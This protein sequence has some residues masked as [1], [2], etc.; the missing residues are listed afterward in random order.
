MLA[1][2]AIA[3]FLGAVGAGC[4]WSADDAKPPAASPDAKTD[5]PPLPPEASVKQT[6]RVAGRTISY[7]ASVGA[8]SVR[9]DKGK[10]TAQVVYT[11]FILD[12]PREPSRPVTFA[13]N[14]GPG[15]ASVFLDFGAIG[16]ERLEFGAAGDVPSDPAR[17]IDNDGTWL[18]F[19]DLVCIDPVGT[20]FSRSLV[21][22]DETKKAFWA[23]KPDIEYLSRIVYDW[24]L[25]NGRMAS[26]K[27]LVGESYGGFRGP[28]ITH[29]PQTQLG[30]G[31]SG[32][33]LV[34]PFLD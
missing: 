17:T 19:T 4:A 23:T 3:A 10:I 24:L 29:Y 28:R 9:D 22:A 34:S 12:G 26:P 18:D 8:L 11:A 32:V 16:P 6:T 5:L 31:V 2:V 1:A 27:Y 7:T 30:V 21:G 14:G 13:F 33:V 20:G 15:A 25:K